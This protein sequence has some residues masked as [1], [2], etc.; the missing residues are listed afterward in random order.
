MKAPTIALLTRAMRTDARSFVPYAGRLAMAGIVFFILLFIG[1]EMS[2]RRS[3]A[4]GLSFFRALSYINFWA[5]T[6]AALSYFSSAIT[7]E[8]EEMTLGLLKMTGL[9]PISILLGKSTC[10]LI[11]TVLLLAAQLPFTMLAITFGGISMAQIVATYVALLAY[12]FMA[13]NLAL[14]FSV[15]TPRTGYAAFFTGLVLAAFFV[16]PQVFLTTFSL[17]AGGWGG[18]PSLEGGW[19]WI[20]GFC[21]T[22]SEASVLTRMSHILS[23]A[24][25]GEMVTMQVLSNVI[26]GLALFSAAWA[27]FDLA[28]RSQKESSPSRFGVFRRARAL[29][30][31]AVGKIW[32]QPLVWKDYYFMTGGKLMAAG[33]VVA[34]FALV[35]AAMVIGLTAFQEPF[36]REMF[37]GC[38]IGFALGMMALDLA[39]CASRV[40]NEEIKWKTL[41]SL[42]TLP[43]TAGAV[44]W[45]KVKGCLIAQIPYLACVMLGMLVVPEYVAEFIAEALFSVEGLALMA[46]W[47]SYYAFFL[48][49]TAYLSLILN[50]GALAVAFLICTFG[51]LLA[52]MFLGMIIGI[53]FAFISALAVGAGM[54]SSFIV[55]ILAMIPTSIFIVLCVLIHFR[56]GPRLEVKAGQL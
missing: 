42:I 14:L 41:P 2:A 36:G 46:F 25:S 32:S 10:R 50:R 11:S 4:P 16:A 9:N 19:G 56:I 30:L 29:P 26:A 24:Y 49:L 54:P 38:L 23:S 22:L 31:F 13:S 5:I 40:F 43:K 8:K 20:A 17:T 27:L 3:G 39:V 47:L 18:Q 53:F 7:E 55:A 21:I 28:T 52:G 34:V 44:A 1:L 45:Q 37:G 35:F 48:Y 51:V 15:V 33:R 12:L 6:I